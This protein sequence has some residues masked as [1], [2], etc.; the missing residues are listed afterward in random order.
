MVVHLWLAHIGCEQRRETIK[1]LS[2]TTLY[3]DL[4]H[5]HQHIGE[6]MIKGNTNSQ[7]QETVNSKR[8]LENSEQNLA[9]MIESAP[10]VKT[11]RNGTGISKPIIEGLYGNRLPILNQGIAQSGQQWGNDHAPEIDPLSADKIRVIKG[12][13]SLEYKAIQMGAIILIENN[14][15]PTD[16]HIHGRVS[17]YYETNGHAIGSH[18]QLGRKEKTFSWKTS[19]TFKHSGDR[20][21]ADYYLRNTGNKEI[22]FSGVAEALLFKKWNTRL[23]F[24]TFNSELGV[25]RGSHISNLTDL[26]AA[27]SRSQPFFTSD[28]FSYTI[29]SPRQEVNHH[30]WKINAVKNIDT[31]RKIELI[32]AGQINARR[33]YDVRRS[34]R[35]A[36][37][38]LSLIQ[39]SNF[40]EI[41]LTKTTEK[42]TRKI[43]AQINYVE[44][45]N[46]PETGVLPLIPNYSS[47]EPS[48]YYT[49]AWR[50]DRSSLEFG[51]RYDL[52][53]Q[54]VYTLT[55]NIPRQDIRHSQQLHHFATTL[56]YRLLFSE[57]IQA[58]FNSGLT[59]RSPYINE[60]YSFGLHQGISSIE[61]GNSTLKPE[62]SFKTSF[63]ISA[64]AAES[65]F[66]DLHGYFQNVND[67]VFLR[68]TNETRLTIRGAYP[69]FRYEQTHAQIIGGDISCRWEPTSRVS[70]RSSYSYLRGW[71]LAA[72]TPLIY[73][74][75]NSWQNSIGIDL[76]RIKGEMSGIYTFRQAN[77]NPDQDF[78]AVPD[79]YFIVQSRIST[80][81]QINK[82][83]VSAY[84]KGTNLLNTSYRDYLNRLRYFADD[85]GRNLILGATVQF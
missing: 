11:I 29:E 45:I 56:G 22:N 57:H 6:V 79:P 46:Q 18:L 67:Y 3:F 24:S 61:E 72:Q 71:D 27:L 36:I 39:Y 78:I 49:Q 7:I 23:S 59:I 70:L 64:H 74:P 26:Q 47:L 28:E 34:N 25:L 13:S 60:L 20:S 8:I 48:I 83:Q 44:N 62:Q 65:F 68:P 10:G 63:Q 32:Y 41:K 50:Y 31:S 75:A 14:Q 37:P 21:S 51:S 85:M 17:S 80:V 9:T 76:G 40:G 84:L 19:G 12:A 54:E 5:Y 35:S 15:M 38:A 2:D 81:F 82:L 4:R 42:T 73:M 33:E 52:H 16:P 1:I 69:V 53:L 58:I 43:G 30:F 66:V 55:Q 77:L